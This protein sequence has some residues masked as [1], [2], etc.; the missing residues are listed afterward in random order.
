MATGK[1]T[2]CTPSNGTSSRLLPFISHCLDSFTTWRTVFIKQERSPTHRTLHETFGARHPSSVTPLTGRASFPPGEAKGAGAEVNRAATNLPSHI[3]DGGDRFTVCTLL[4]GTSSK[5]LPLGFPRGKPRRIVRIRP[6]FHKT[7]SA[8][9]ETPLRLAKSRLTAVARLHGAC[10][11]LS[12]PLRAASSPIGSQGDLLP[13]PH[14]DFGQGGVGI[15]DDG[16][17]GAGQALF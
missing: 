6:R 7:A 12:Q 15:Q 10:A 3:L 16:F 8:C 9:R 14:E 4:N 13:C 2:V 1:N 11:S 5:S 17:F